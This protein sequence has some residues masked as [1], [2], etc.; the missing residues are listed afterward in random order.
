MKHQIWAASFIWSTECVEER[1]F[2][3]LTMNLSNETGS[4]L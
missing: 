2:G 4:P 3:Q 1:D